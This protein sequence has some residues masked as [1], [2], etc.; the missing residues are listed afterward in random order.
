M[1]EALDDSFALE[2]RRR[3]ALFWGWAK[4]GPRNRRLFARGSGGG[5]GPEKGVRGLP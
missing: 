3:D 4:R 5:N 1:R 2:K